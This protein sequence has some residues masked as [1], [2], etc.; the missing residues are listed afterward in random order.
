MIWLRIIDWV[1]LVIVDL[2]FMLWLIGLGCM[3]MV[4]GLVSFRCFLVRL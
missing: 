4:F 3:M 2:I 1:L